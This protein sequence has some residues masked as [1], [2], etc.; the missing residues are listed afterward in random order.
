MNSSYPDLCVA[1]KREAPP[2][3]NPE[4]GARHGRLAIEAGHHLV[5]VSKEVDSVVGPYLAAYA[6]RH[7]KVVTPVDGDQPSLLIGLITW[8]QTLG[9][10]ILAAG[11]SSE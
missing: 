1:G 2:S 7:G 8:A 3:G 10:E 4:A 6:R 11:K 5:L 9:F